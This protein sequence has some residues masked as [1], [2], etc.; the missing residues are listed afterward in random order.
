MQLSE[1]TLT[2]LKNFSA[3]NTGLFF[4]QG[5]LLRTVSPNKTVLAEATI[6]ETIPT[7]FGVHEL[8]QLLAIISL[9]KTPPVIDVKGNDLVVKSPNG[10]SKITYRCCAA[11]MI[12][13]PPDKSLELP[14]EDLQFTLSEEDYNWIIKSSSVLGNPNI[15]ISSHE[16]KLYLGT[17]D[18]SNDAA[19]T[20]SVEL[21]NY[22]GPSV[23][24]TFK[25]ENWKMIPGDYTV[26]IS[27]KG[28]ALFKSTTRKIQ[29]WVATETKK[30]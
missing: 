19:S 23:H 20:D 18:T 5:N 9:Y 3:I 29:Y 30:K 4:K 14:S 10:K 2:V 16:G 24:F 7:D 28:I 6:D 15:S 13:M 12:K 22:E 21:K 11:N 1:N 8:N 27:S 26:S 25:T 17:S